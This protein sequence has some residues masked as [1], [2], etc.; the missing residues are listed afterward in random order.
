MN[1]KNHQMFGLT[2]LLLAVIFFVASGKVTANEE[3]DEDTYGPANPIIWTKPVKSV[4]FTHKIHTMD[5]GLECDNCHDDIFQ[6]EAGTAEEN[7]DFTMK[8]L[9]DG[10]YCGACHDGD[11]AFAANTRCTTCHIGVKGHRRLTGTPK[12]ESH[13][14]GH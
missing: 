3:Y 4:V 8:S 7:E 14:G 10:K 6:M 13:G 1:T 9:Y 2:A 11:T 12:N 5:A